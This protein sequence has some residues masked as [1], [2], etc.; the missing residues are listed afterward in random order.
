MGR[1]YVIEHCVS[2]INRYREKEIYNVYVTECLRIIAGAVGRDI[3]VSYTSIIEG[4]KPQ[5]V[6]EETR[7]PEEIIS[8]IR[9]KLE[10]R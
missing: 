6:H 2:A 9:N 7:T 3:N 1:G 5:R 8:N 4:V 10:G